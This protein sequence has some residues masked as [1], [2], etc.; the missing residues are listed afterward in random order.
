M[1][2]IENTGQRNLPFIAQFL[3]MSYKFDSKL[4]F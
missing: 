3:N 2:I 1:S 4:N